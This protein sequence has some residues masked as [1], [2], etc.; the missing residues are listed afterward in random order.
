TDFIDDKKAKSG[1]KVSGLLNGLN[2]VDWTTSTKLAQKNWIGQSEG[3]E[4]KFFITGTEDE[5]TVF[6][7]RLDTIFGC[8]YI[9]VAPEHALLKRHEKKIRNG[10][11]VKGYLKKTARKTDLER[12]EL[13]RIKTGVL[14]EGIEA[15]HPFTGKRL[16]VYVADYVLS[17]YGT[18]AVMGVPA[19]DERD[20]E[21]AT[22][23]D[24][25]ITAVIAPQSEG[26]SEKKLFTDDGVLYDSGEYSALTSDEA[27]KKMMAWLRKEKLGGKKV[28]SRLRDWLISR[29]RY[30]GAPIP[31]IYCE[32]CGAVPVPEKDLPVKLPTDVDFRPTG[33]SPLVRSKSFHKVKCPKCGTS[34][35]RESDTMDTFVCSSWYYLRFADPKNTKQFASKKMLEKYLPVDFY[36]GGA[37][38]TVLHLL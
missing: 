5:I 27:R 26:S 9:V 29:Q 1:R 20:F 14:V 15:A 28:N 17:T 38:H 8:T 18:G 33:E 11:E 25:P 10:S 7:T 16:P 36:M 35:R 13:N 21:F 12:T 37:E 23:Y 30:W 4:V 34:A 3:A 2:T 32:T 6:T 22:K 19:H 24:L 31:I